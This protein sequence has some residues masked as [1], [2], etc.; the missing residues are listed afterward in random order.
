MHPFTE[1]VILFRIVFVVFCAC[2]HM[3]ACTHIL[4][5]CLFFHF[6]GA[7]FFL[8]HQG[9]Y[10]HQCR[11]LSI[12]LQ[13]LQFCECIFLFQLTS[14]TMAMDTLTFMAI[15]GPTFDSLPPFQWSKAVNGSSALHLGQ[16]DLF[17]FGP[18]WFNGTF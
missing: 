14:V 16:P 11:F 8:L 12:L 1:P 9:H 4:F 6:H 3:Y 2:A 15:S 10:C 5:F 17:N 18:V 7:L 13:H